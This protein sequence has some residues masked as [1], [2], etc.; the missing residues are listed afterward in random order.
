MTDVPGTSRAA[1]TPPPSVATLRAGTLVGGYELLRRL[2]SGGMGVVWE[3]RDGGGQ[4]VAMKIL[5]PQ[6]AADPVV[7]AQNDTFDRTSI[8]QPFVSAMNNCWTP[9]ENMGKAIRNG[10]V[11]KENAAEQT[12]AMNDAMNS[13]GI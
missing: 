8:L 11:T 2:G 12:K 5:H 6:I 3:A 7:Q 1:G 13:N 4:R 9:V 10:S